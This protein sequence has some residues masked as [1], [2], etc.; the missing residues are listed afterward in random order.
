MQPK[1]ASF[2]LELSGELLDVVSGHFGILLELM[3]SGVESVDGVSL[4]INHNRY[5]CRFMGSGKRLEL[6]RA[7]IATMLTLT[8]SSLITC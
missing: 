6:N 8:E 1:T 5:E 7:S 3:D 2:C 4:G